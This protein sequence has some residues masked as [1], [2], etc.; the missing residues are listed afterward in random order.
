MQVTL[1]ISYY[2]LQNDFISPID[3]F[4]AGLEQKGLTVAVGKMSTSMVGEY[5]VVMGVLKETMRDFM[6]EH[7]SVFNLKI[8]NFVHP[9]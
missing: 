3:D 7:P 4:I 5:D 8:T 2:P 9:D 1:D 6:E